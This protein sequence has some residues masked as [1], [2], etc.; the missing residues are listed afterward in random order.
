[1]VPG[2]LPEATGE[3]QQG[4][5]TIGKYSVQG[6]TLSHSEEHQVHHSAHPVKPMELFKHKDQSSSTSQASTRKGALEAWSP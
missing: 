6:T 2:L 1:M 3:P 4:D 5:K